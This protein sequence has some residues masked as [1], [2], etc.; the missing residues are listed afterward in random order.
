MYITDINPY[1]AIGDIHQAQPAVDE[2]GRPAISKKIVQF[3]F[4]VYFYLSIKDG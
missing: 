3:R 1:T 2:S 4:A